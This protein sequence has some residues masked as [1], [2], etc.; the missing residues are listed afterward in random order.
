[1]FETPYQT[2]Q[3]YSVLNQGHARCGKK[4]GHPA[5]ALFWVLVT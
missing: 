3:N 1:M 2:C 4:R 5:S